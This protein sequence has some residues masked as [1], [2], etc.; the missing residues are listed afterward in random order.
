MYHIP[1]SWGT[2]AAIS[3]SSSL[4]ATPVT[5]DTHGAKPASPPTRVHHLPVPHLSW[6][7]LKTQ[8]LGQVAICHLLQSLFQIL[9]PGPKGHTQPGA[10]WCVRAVYAPGHVTGAPGWC[11]AHQQGPQPTQPGQPARTRRPHRGSLPPGLSNIE[12]H[13]IAFFSNVIFN[14]KL[15]VSSWHSF[16]EGDYHYYYYYLFLLSCCLV[17]P[18]WLRRYC[19]MN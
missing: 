4:G 1:D 9:G 10:G 18:W 17:T 16:K 7:F 13:S 6:L 19:E 8:A 11:W 3:S 12:M 5:S 15:N 14:R 2:A